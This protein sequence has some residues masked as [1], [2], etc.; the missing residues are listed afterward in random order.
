VDGDKESPEFQRQAA[1]F[2]TAL[3]GMGRL[4]GRFTLSGKNH[5]EVPNELN[6]AGT[7]LSRTVLAMMKK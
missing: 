6:H 4:A 5:F 7:D 2:A 1:G 3:A